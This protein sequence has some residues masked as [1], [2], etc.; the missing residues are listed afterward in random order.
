MLPNTLL[1]KPTENGTIQPLM[2][3]LYSLFVQLKMKRD[4]E[5]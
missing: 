4:E 3:E 5:T 1:Y 2:I